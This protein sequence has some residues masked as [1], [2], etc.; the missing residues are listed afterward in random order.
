MYSRLAAVSRGRCALIMDDSINGAQTD[1]DRALI[2]RSSSIMK[3]WHLQQQ[4]QQHQQPQRLQEVAANRR[5]ERGGNLDRH[6]AQSIPAC[7]QNGLCTKT[8]IL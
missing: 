1:N 4:R 6:T 5:S 7:N 8:R 2:D 3:A